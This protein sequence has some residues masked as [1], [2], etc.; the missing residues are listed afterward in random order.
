[1]KTTLALTLLVASLAA[2]LQ[3]APA[4]QQADQHRRI[5][6]Q[7]RYHA[8]RGQEAA[9]LAVRLEGS[10]IRKKLGLPAGAIFVRQGEAGDGAT[11]IWECE[12]PT[13]EARRDDVAQTKASP[14]F[15]AVQRKMQALTEKVERLN[16]EEHT[17]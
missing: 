15:A 5:L 3:A 4:P 8:K 11:V 17:D 9:V 14:E 6:A 13:I 16:W 2:P 1:M 10:S 7:N 12:Y